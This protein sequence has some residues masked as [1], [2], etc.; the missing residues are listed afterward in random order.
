M[1]FFAPLY[2]F[3]VDLT[4]EHFASATQ[5]ATRMPPNGVDAIQAQ[6]LAIQSDGGNRP[7]QKMMV[8]GRHGHCQILEAAMPELPSKWY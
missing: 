8:H 2:V 1:K 6:A 4:C 5:S 3:V 7:W